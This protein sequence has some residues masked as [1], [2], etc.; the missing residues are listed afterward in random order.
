MDAVFLVCNT[1]ASNVVFW[2]A[3]ITN[4]NTNINQNEHQPSTG[5]SL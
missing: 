2:I 1:T 4:V 3:A 5:L